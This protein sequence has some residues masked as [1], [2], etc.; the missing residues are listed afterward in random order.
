[1]TIEI[2]KP[3]STGWRIP[4]NG[5]TYSPYV[6]GNGR[7]AKQIAFA[8]SDN[9]RLDQE[10]NNIYDNELMQTTDIGGF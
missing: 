9:A 3:R 4:V 10:F 2:L 6:I 1:M 8:Y 7:T 5:K